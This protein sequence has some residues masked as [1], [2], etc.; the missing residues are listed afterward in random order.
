MKASQDRSRLLTAMCGQV[1]KV[2]GKVSPI[3]LQQVKASGIVPDALLA[4][5][6]SPEF[7]EAREL[8]RLSRPFDRAL[9]VWRTIGLEGEAS[10]LLLNKLIERGDLVQPA[11]EKASIR[12]SLAPTTTGKLKVGRIRVR[13]LNFLKGAGADQ[14]IRRIASS[15]TIGLLPYDAAYYIRLS[16]QGQPDDEYVWVA[17]REITNAMPW[18]VIFRLDNNEGHLVF[19]ARGLGTCGPDE[20]LF[21]K[22]L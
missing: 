21:V 17:M 13:D 2:G 15:T 14:I 19:E 20:E 1:E 4:D 7:E 10:D 16:Y 5:P 12:M 9:K 11:A 6:N 3:K 18:S 8:L 22:I